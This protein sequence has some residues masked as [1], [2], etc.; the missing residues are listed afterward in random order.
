MLIS[1]DATRKDFEPAMN[2]ISGLI[3]AAVD[4][5]VSAFEKQERNNP[6]LA[7]HFRETYALEFAL[8][9]ARRYRRNTGRVPKGV[10]FHPLY[11]FL[12]PAH[13]IHDALPPE[14]KGPF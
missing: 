2:W 5:Q 1:I 12:I 3:G 9:Q 7:A 8:A 14:A 10:D 13:R 4:K 11:S 6:L